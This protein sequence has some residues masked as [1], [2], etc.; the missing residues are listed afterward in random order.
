M[1]EIITK[2]KHQFC[3]AK[4]IDTVNSRDGIIIDEEIK[5]TYDCII[6]ITFFKNQFEILFFKRGWCVE[7]YI[8]FSN[9]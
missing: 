9:I 3:Y 1:K 2:I 6:K 8:K 7:V 5:V 4:I